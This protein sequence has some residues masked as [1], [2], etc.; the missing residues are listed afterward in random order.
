MKEIWK[1]IVGYEGL[2]QVSD[3][4]RVKS[5]PRWGTTKEEK[6]LKQYKNRYGYMYVCL[7]KNSKPKKYT[8]H[9]L[10]AKAFIPNP[11]NKPEVNHKKG[12]KADNRASELEWATKSEN[13]KH[14]YK[15]LNEK[16]YTKQVICIETGKMYNS[17][18]EASKEC[19]CQKTHISDCCR[20]RRNTTGGYHWKYKD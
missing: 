15:V 16:H 8:V 13:K 1:D 11:E 19:G 5:M 6:T 9:T 2:Y 12:N 3:F 17:L 20:G 18:L 10:V 4:G 7:Y 14:S